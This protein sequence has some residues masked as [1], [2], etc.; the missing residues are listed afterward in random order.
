MIDDYRGLAVFVAVVD[1]GSFSAAARRMK[2]ST[3]VVSH[4]VSKLE[5][6]VGTPLFHR[7]TRS[8]SLTSD[9]EKM[10][11][12]ARRMVA[13]GEEAIDALAAEQDQPVGQLRVSLPAFGSD[14]PLHHA[15]WA[16]AR[17]H[18]L[19][20]LSLNHSD[21]PVN[22][23]RDGFDMAI[24]LGVLA[25][26][27]LKSRKIGTF[28]RALVAS[29]AYLQDRRPIET[30]D[31][32]VSQKFVSVS[33]LPK[34]ITLYREGETVAFV[35][36]HYAIEVDTIMAAVAAVRAGI[37]IFHLPKGEINA[38]LASGDLIEVFPKWQLAEL[39]VYAIWPDLGPRKQ[40]TQRLLNFLVQ[41]LPD[42]AV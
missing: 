30:L 2:L 27:S 23:V 22:L 6:K 17:A 42:Q 26:S 11:D 28:Q 41:I 34:R 15:L 39:G 3:S 9:G 36:D 32:L 25:D 12:A 40:L 4:H 31:D 1:A 14:T 18:P 20:T 29:P 10:V 16:F 19:V 33:I 35:P 7:S 13:A 21:Q 5:A 37:G 24:R 8:L 38:D